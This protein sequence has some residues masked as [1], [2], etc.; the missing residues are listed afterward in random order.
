MTRTAFVAT[1]GGQPQVITFALDLLYARGVYPNLVLI[2]HLSRRNPRVRQALERLSQEFSRG[3]YKGKSCA[4]HTVEIRQDHHPLVDIRNAADAEEVWRTFHK[5]FTDLKVKHHVI[6]LSIAGGRRLMGHLAMS[7]ATFLFDRSD[8]IW[9]LYTP[10]HI[11]EE[12]REGRRMHP[13][14]TDGAQLIEVPFVPLGAIFPAL[15]ELAHASPSE[16]RAL[17]MQWLDAMTRQRCRQV[18]SNLTAR[19]K[20][21][22]RLLASGKTPKEVAQALHITLAT[23]NSHK[24]VILAET[25]IAWGIPEGEWLDYRFLQD[26]F[27]PCL[28]ELEGS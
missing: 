9:H 22:L 5:V 23:V 1:L 12:V 2:V 21:V 26:K 20:E 4:Y 3:Q 7:A 16:I 25:R 10:D 27:G 11:Q 14:P 8:H 13:R 19:Q 17:Q 15:R 28:R 6:H 18:W 24:T